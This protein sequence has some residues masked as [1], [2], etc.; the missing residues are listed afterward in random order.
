VATF[1][2]GILWSTSGGSSWSPIQAGLPSPTWTGSLAAHP[3]GG[4]LFLG[5]ASVWQVEGV[6]PVELTGFAVE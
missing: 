3:F 4:T 5:A 1:D 2:S 6:F